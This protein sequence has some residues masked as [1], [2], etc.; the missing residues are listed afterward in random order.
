MDVGVW[1]CVISGV[2]LSVLVL[3][4]EDKGLVVS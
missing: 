2:G 4:E 3:C 1:G